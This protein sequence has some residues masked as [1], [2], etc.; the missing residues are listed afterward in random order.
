MNHEQTLLKRNFAPL[1]V[2]TKKEEN[3]YE[4][5]KEEEKKFEEVKE[6]K[7]GEEP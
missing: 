6:E 2:I 7:K 5:A 4:E 3:K 1:S